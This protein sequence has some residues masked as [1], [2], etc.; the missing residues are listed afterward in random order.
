M[1]VRN[2][3]R[4][5]TTVKFVE[6]TIFTFAIRHLVRLR[7]AQLPFES[8][9]LN[10]NGAR[11]A[12][13]QVSK[14]TLTQT[15]TH[16]PDEAYLVDQVLHA[17]K[18]VSPLAGRGFGAMP[19]SSFNAEVQRP[20]SV[21]LHLRTRW[22]VL[23]CHVRLRAFRRRRKSFPMSDA[24]PGTALRRLTVRQKGSRKPH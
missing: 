12:L 22:T 10:T 18:L 16:R 13:T 2:Q 8:T 24:R 15:A 23:Y 5:A 11:S 19:H 20:R 3:P 6:P 1:Q 14:G 21:G 17:S 7:Q 9:Y 4:S